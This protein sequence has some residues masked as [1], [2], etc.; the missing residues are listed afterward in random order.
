MEPKPH[1]RRIGATALRG[2]PCAP[3]SDA[4]VSLAIG[5]GD[6]AA[7]GLAW[8]RY[9]SAVR[10]WL[11]AR[12][13]SDQSIDDLLQE[14]FLGLWRSAPRMTEPAYLRAYLYAIAL[15]LVA[16]ELR[17]RS[18]RGRW[19]QLTRSGELPEI[20]WSPTIVEE[21]D[22]VRAL[23]DLLQ[24]LEA[25]ERTSFLLRYVEELSLPE[26]AL[27]L[28]VSQATAK[29]LLSRARERVLSLALTEPA[30]AQYNAARSDSIWRRAL[31]FIGASAALV[32]R[33]AR[34]ILGCAWKS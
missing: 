14:V 24:S 32:R 23:N 30:L 8:D 26:V 17:G 21:R 34:W 6:R 22:S 2:V 10:R 31:S 27:A 20:P 7:L 4:E 28:G 3:L 33:T 16:L 1:P 12:L 18:R 29:R 9:S 19:F 13:G 15:K 5:R 11:L 25:R